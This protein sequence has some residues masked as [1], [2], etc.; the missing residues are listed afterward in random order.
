MEI[1]T[2]FGPSREE[3]I[4]DIQAIATKLGVNGLSHDR[5]MI[6]G[7]LYSKS[8]IC[9]RFST[10]VNA[11]KHAGLKSIYRKE[12]TKRKKLPLGIRYNVFERDGFRC[13]ACG[14]S[15]DDNDYIVLCVDHIIPLSKGGS[16]TMDNLQTLCA[17]CNLG[18]SNTTREKS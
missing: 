13:R 12:V 14:I 6:N 5:Y 1:P 7:G 9:R 15:R 4:A 2:K 3:I 16:S 18:K 8:I 17:A 10:W 11:I